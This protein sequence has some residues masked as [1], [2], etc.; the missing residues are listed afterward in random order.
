MSKKILLLV[1]LFFVFS[2]SLSNASGYTFNRELSYGDSGADVSALQ[3]TLKEADFFNHDSITGYFGLVTKEAVKKFQVSKKIVTNSLEDSG[4]GRVGPK[5]LKVL[6]SISKPTSN[7]NTSEVKPPSSTKVKSLE[8]ELYIGLRGEDVKSLQLFLK[9]KGFFTYPTLT[10]YFGEITKKAVIAFQSSQKIKQTGEVDPV[11]FKKIV[12]LSEVVPKEVLKAPV[13]SEVTAIP[14]QTADKTPN[15][16]FSTDSAGSIIYGGSCS[17]STT[18]VIVGVNTITLNSLSDGLYSGCT[19]KVIDAKGLQSNILTIPTFRINTIVL[20]SGGSTP[21]VVIDSTAPIISEVTPVVTPGSDI[22]PSY[23]FTSDEAG[24]I[25]YT[26]SCTSAT[27]LATVGLNTIVF[28]AL[29]DGTYNT[30]TLKV[31]DSASNISNIITISSFVI[32]TTAPT[33]TNIT[34]DK[35]N[36]TY[37]DNEVIDIDVTFSE[38]ITSTGSITVTLETGDVDSSCTF[39]ATNSSTGTCNY[40]VQFTDSSADLTVLSIAGT[41]ADQAGNAMTNFVPS[42]NLAANKALVISNYLAD[43]VVSP[44][45]AYSNRKLRSDYLGPAT[46]IRRSSDNGLSDIGFNAGDYDTSAFSTFVGGGSGAVRT[47]YDQ[48]NNGVNAVQTTNG[49]QLLVELN[50]V[51]SKPTL[52][53]A[54]GK[55]MSFTS[56]TLG[57][58][59]DI[60]GVFNLNNINSGFLLGG[61]NGG[62]W[63]DLLYYDATTVSHGRAAANDSI[64]YTIP[65]NSWLLAHIRRVD[66]KWASLSINGEIVGWYDLGNNNPISFNRLVSEDPS[67]SVATK[68]AEQIYYTGGLTEAQVQAISNN[69]SNYYDIDL[70]SYSPYVT[71]YSLELLDSNTEFP[72]M[73]GVG[74]VSFENNLRLLGGWNTGIFPGSGSTNTDWQSSDGVTWTQNADASWSVRHAVAMDVKDSK[75]WVF[76]GDFTTLS[77]DVWTYTTAG[78]WT[79]RTADWGSDGGNRGLYAW[80]IHDNS[81]YFAGGQS[82]FGVSPTMHTDIIRYNETTDQFEKMGDLPIA[83]FSTGILY[84][85]N[86]DLYMIGGGR[87]TSGGSDNY[88]NTV[89]KSI[90]DGANWTLIATLP[91]AMRSMYPNGVV[92]DNKMWYLMGGYSSVNQEGLYS[93]SDGI[94]WQKEQY[95]GARHASGIVVHNGALHI[96]AGNLYNDS[97]RVVSE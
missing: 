21:T 41:I 60:F 44:L 94:T 31:T 49:S 78:G 24:T 57:T 77:K 10:G 58:T 28:S 43:L 62:T 84:S 63:A 79:Q 19:V 48:S 91:N 85:F 50:Q 81:F 36:G 42:T 83:N 12:D 64:T 53:N 76:G 14:V 5:T 74:L 13:I 45:L 87:Y 18:L 40:T 56:Q 33:I 67:L 88:N 73:D 34:S 71:P 68:L 97:W 26:G 54:A 11:T 61:N 80:T 29:A 27:V 23:V 92:F 17:S 90:D 65:K 86:G 70:Q 6:N 30:C 2:P 55:D 38:A 4:Y 39:T 72:L 47:W 7:V 20:R 37:G 1:S 82:D 3:Q 22:T 89:Y 16:T 93:S 75:I 52:L 95:P 66:S 8:R 15:Y 46:Q 9:N 51:N 69:I 96:V 32:D 59:Y 35:T 25:T